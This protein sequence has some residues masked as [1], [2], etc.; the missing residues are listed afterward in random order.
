[1]TVHAASNVAAPPVVV[2]LPL[3]AFPAELPPALAEPPV[4]APL[5]LPAF[6]LVR[7][8]A[9]KSARERLFTEVLAA[10][11]AAALGAET[12]LQNKLVLIQS[13]GEWWQRSPAVR[14]AL[15][16]LARNDPDATIRKLPQEAVTAPG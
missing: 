4:L 13:A 8:G 7:S 3:V 14:Q 12:D 1:M 9:A 5:A 6:A 15:E 10:A 16:A 11:L 2:L